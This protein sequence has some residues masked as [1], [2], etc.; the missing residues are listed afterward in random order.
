MGNDRRNSFWADEHK[1]RKLWWTSPP[2]SNFPGF[3]QISAFRPSFVRGLATFP[4]A[5]GSQEENFSPSTIFFFAKGRRR[6]HFSLFTHTRCW[7]GAAARLSSD[8]CWMLDDCFGEIRLRMIFLSRSPLEGAYVENKG[9][10]DCCRLECWWQGKST[11]SY[12]GPHSVRFTLNSLIAWRTN[13]YFW[14]IWIA[15]LR[16]SYSSAITKAWFSLN[17]EWSF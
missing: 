12:F 14:V 1:I 15:H 17:Y 5:W 4:P 3:P 6:I 9:K 8:C 2:A 16:C 7:N 13:G 11:C 10:Q